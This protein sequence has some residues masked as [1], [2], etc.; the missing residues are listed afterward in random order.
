[1][2]FS[3]ASPAV[4]RRF[5]GAALRI[6]HTTDL[7]M[8]L[9]AYDY[10]L[11]RQNPKLGLSR[12]ASLIKQA[13]GEVDASLLFDT[14]DFLQGNLLGEHINSQGR[15][16][17]R[18][19]PAI[20]AMNLLNYDA[21]TLG[22]HEFSYG[23]NFLRAAL[24]GAEF[25]VV[26]TNVT[27]K[28]GSKPTPDFLPR[29]SLLKRTVQD[30]NGQSHPITLGAIGFIPPQT[31]I[32]E[33][34]HVAQHLDFSD[35]MRSARQVVPHVKAAGAD[36]I[37]ALCH[38]GIAAAH[39]PGARENAALALSTIDGIDVL[40][41]GHQHQR[42]P[43]PDFDNIAGVDPV[44]GT[45]NGKPALMPGYWG[46]H[47]GVMDIRLRRDPRA[48]WQIDGHHC[49]L[50]AVAEAA[51]KATAIPPATMPT[52]TEA[53]ELIHALRPFHDGA[54]AYGQTEIATTAQ[55][56]NS[57][58]S[59]VSADTG[60]HLIANAKIRFVRQAL[61]TTELKDIP[62][63]AAVSPF[64]AGGPAGP[65]HYVAIAKGVF[66]QK[67]LVALYQFPN[68]MAAVKLT[69]A[70]IREWLEQVSGMFNQITPGQSDQPLHRADFPSYRFDHLIGLDYGFD[71][72]QPPRYDSHLNLISPASHRVTHLNWQGR[73]VAPQQQFI[74]ACSS[75]RAAGSGFADLA[76]HPALD[77]EPTRIRDIVAAYLK[78]EPNPFQQRHPNW[79]FRAQPN[80]SVM[81]KTAAAAAPHLQE[82]PRLRMTA[83]DHDNDGFLRVRLSL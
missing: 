25:D 31:A 17:A 8:H 10:F 24:S 53:P 14:G 38:T 49:S 64:R 28:A 4:Q 52:A 76:T 6:L 82:I 56:I 37:V 72:S 71:L 40:L 12:V 13:R 69:G 81:F 33:R 32:W 78:E 77:I 9:S 79:V 16:A 67:D 47:L 23:V 43:S 41:C 68:V 61:A 1:M 45:L 3:I 44:L 2:T 59:L 18:H 54:L 75:F 46:S 60:L 58:F 22:N 57:F 11:D 15:N 65:N 70:E 83:L 26:L 80:T 5:G 62:V 34:H 66:T 7:H 51:P 42:F 27:R 30:K 36:L 48:G 50:R 29:F 55:P 20:M 39:S 19:H 63:L 21:C 74:V 35:F 73:P